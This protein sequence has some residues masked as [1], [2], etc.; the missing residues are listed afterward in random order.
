MILT[1][2]NCTTRFRLD[3]EALAP[4]GRMVRCSRCGHRWFVE[5]P[6]EA[7]AAGAAEAGEAA[8]IEPKP[9]TAAPAAAV[10]TARS[11]PPST[12]STVGWLLLLLIALLLAGLVLGRN[13][14]AA[15]LPGTAAIYTRLGLP[16][17]L[18]LALEFRNLVARREVE[19]GSV[20]LVVEGEIHNLADADRLVPPIRL[21]LVD[22]SGRELDF[23]LF[24]PPLSVLPPGGMTPFE[25]RLLDPPE[26]A[27]SFVV[28][29]TERPV[30]PGE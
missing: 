21:S 1:C 12:V 15:A 6:P 17:T 16:V 30:E 11:R 2:P 5:L 19:N 27:G 14:I 3:P 20:V 4:R 29:F 10:A 9:F 13:E 25:A 28:T 8:A 26:G 24:D 22:R 23:G 18:P 7:G